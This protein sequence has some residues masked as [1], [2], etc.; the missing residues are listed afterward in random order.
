ME[1]SSRSESWR[2]LRLLYGYEF[3]DPT[4]DILLPERKES[5]DAYII[6]YSSLPSNAIGTAV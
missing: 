3:G 6:L 2:S 4:K 5:T 1:K